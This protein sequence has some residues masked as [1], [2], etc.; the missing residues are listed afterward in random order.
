MGRCRSRRPSSGNRH[1]S[2]FRGRSLLGVSICPTCGAKGVPALFGLP[3]EAGRLAG[4]AGDLA[5]MGCFEP[6][7]PPHYTCAAEHTWRA[8]ERQWQAD[9]LDALGKHGHARHSLD[10]E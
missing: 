7:E 9:L 3:V 1:Y 8:D 5:L 10:D 4:Q 6:E 2:R